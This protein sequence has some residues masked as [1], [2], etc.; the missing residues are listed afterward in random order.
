MITIIINYHCYWRTAIALKTITISVNCLIYLA[1]TTA[2]N[3][4]LKWAICLGN[5]KKKKQNKTTLDTAITP[6]KNPSI[7]R[8][9]CTG[10]KSISYL[11]K[12][13]WK[14]VCWCDLNGNSFGVRV[15]GFLFRSF[16]PQNKMVKYKW[17][18]FNNN[19]VAK[20]EHSKMP[21]ATVWISTPSILVSIN[22]K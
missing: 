18:I 3:H 10:H 22:Q 13:I 8:K 15:F 7:E 2:L 9:Q 12:Q 1:I 20:L 6:N 14:W 16:Y 19:N 11:V 21:N 17:E 5:R 4:L